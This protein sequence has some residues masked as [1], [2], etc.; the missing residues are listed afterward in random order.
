VDQIKTRYNKAKE[1]PLTR[2]KLSKKLNL[3]GEATVSVGGGLGGSVVWGVVF[4][5]MVGFCWGVGKR[6][7]KEKYVTLQPSSLRAGNMDTILIR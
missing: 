6:S 7:L 3:W 2:G 1:Q 4:F 5:W